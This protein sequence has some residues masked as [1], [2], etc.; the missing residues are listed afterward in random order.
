MRGFLIAIGVRLTPGSCE[1]LL[2]KREE[3]YKSFNIV[4]QV[5]FIFLFK[6]RKKFN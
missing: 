3:L 5:K 2:P 1:N 4:Y 6:N